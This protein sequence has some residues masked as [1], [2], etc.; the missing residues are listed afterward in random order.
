M[1]SIDQQGSGA[2]LSGTTGLTM[3]DTH[4]SPTGL[5]EI[6]DG[7]HEALEEIS[8]YTVNLVMDFVA[9]D[10]IAK[11]GGKFMLNP[12]CIVYDTVC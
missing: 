6:F 1:E 4:A 11:K 9:G 3:T 8:T 10:T 2:F 5:R 7:P 12:K